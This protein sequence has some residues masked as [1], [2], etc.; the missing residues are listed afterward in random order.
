MTIY[1]MRSD[2]DNFMVFNLTPT[3]LRSKMGRSFRYFINRTPQPQP[4]WVVPDATFR[5]I[6]EFPKAG[7]LPDICDWV[8][9]HPVLNQKAYDVLVNR[10]ESYGEFLPVSIE[11]IPYYIFNILHLVEESFIDTDKSEREFEGEGENR[12]QVGLHKLKFKE[13][14][15]TDTLLFKTEYDTYLNVFCGDDLKNIIEDTGLTGV[16]FKPDL[17]SIF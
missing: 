14:L 9:V 11:G 16:L 6:S 4:N 13:D 17:A 2:H 15:L 12:M 5:K 8:G 1:R 3:E 7:N 10:L